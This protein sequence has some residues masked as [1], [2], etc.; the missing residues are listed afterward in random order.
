MSESN[1]T[2]TI[3]EKKIESEGGTTKD[4]P[5]YGKFLASL[6][7][8]VFV[9]IYFGISS[10]VL[11]ACKIAQS[12]LLPTD[13]DCS[14]YTDNQPKIT[15]IETNIF[16]TLFSDPALSMK[17]NI[18]YDKYNS[19]NIILDT[20][21][22]YKNNPSSF[23]LVNYFISIFEAVV[24]KNFVIFNYIF[25]ILN[26]I[27]EVIIVL[28]GPIIISFIT[29]FIGL[30]DSIY[31]FFYLWFYNM[32]WFFK[33]NTNSDA[34]GKPV[35]ENVTIIEP[36]SYC[37]AIGLVILFTILLFVTAPYILI[38]FMS[39]F[40]VMI[41]MSSY[42]GLMNKKEANIFTI[43]LNI[44]KFYKLFIISIICFFVTTSAFVNLGIVPGLFSLI[45]LG[46]IYYNIIPI[47][48]F[49][50]INLD[51]L[52]QL[53]SDEQA[54]RE[55]CTKNDSETSKKAKHGLLYNMI[56]SEQSGGKNISKQL[57]K[58]N[59]NMNN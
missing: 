46:C 40:F 52:T 15:P 19:K 36:I 50:P 16:K 3:D 31:V 20:L 11:Y 7:I 55:T 42:K 45:V 14:P 54:T 49:A 13:I 6:L 8:I 24:S 1:D 39:I 57:K 21:R 27:P 2:S 58:I 44:L 18:P 34:K 30:F 51:N 12:N 35:W 28:L 33:K 29:P 10:Y 41:T 56:F 32:S 37:F 22:K 43:F 23:F 59:K 9:L 25:N 17:L 48:L 53:V 47:N 5:S 4:S 26:Q 38:S